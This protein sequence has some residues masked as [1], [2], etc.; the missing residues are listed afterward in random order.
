MKTVKFPRV[1]QK[2][3]SENLL[4]ALRLFI[5]ARNKAI[6][7]GFTD[8]GGAIRSVERILD[9]PS[10]HLRYPNPSH[11]NNLKTD[12]GAEIGKAAYAARMVGEPVFIEH[13]LPQTAY[14]QKTI[15]IVN[16]GGGDDDVMTFIKVNYRLVL[17]TRDETT[18]INRI[19]RSKISEDRIADFR[20]E[21]HRLAETWIF[22]P[23]LASY[24]FPTIRTDAPNRADRWG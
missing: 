7:L 2:K 6:E 10:L 8:N 5:E 20:I 24:Q 12:P 3:H 13:V 9:I 18:A 4:P 16:S 14:A 19:N 1:S 17:L 11:I 22:T 21:I 23:A 15:E